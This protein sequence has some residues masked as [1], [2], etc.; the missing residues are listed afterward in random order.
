MKDGDK[1]RNRSFPSDVWTIDYFNPI[2]DYVRI[3]R[4]NVYLMV[5]LLTLYTEY[6]LVKEPTGNHSTCNCGCWIIKDAP[7]RSHSTFCPLFVAAK[8]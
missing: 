7:P 2:Q 3:T 4:D 8:A 5:D 1:V 6:E